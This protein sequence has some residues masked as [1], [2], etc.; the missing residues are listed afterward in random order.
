MKKQIE[1]NLLYNIPSKYIIP[2][3][4]AKKATPE[5][6]K[7]IPTQYNSIDT[8][9]KCIP[10]IDAITVGY[11]LLNHIDIVVTMAADGSIRLPFHNDEHKHVLE[12]F[13]PIETHASAQ[14]KNSPFESFTILKYMSPWYIKTP[15]DY[16]LLFVP[17]INRI[18]S[19]IIPLSGLVD[20]DSF[21]NVV[22]IP[23][24]HTAFEKPG[25]TIIIPAGTP[26]CQIVPIRR[27]DWSTKVTLLDAVTINEVISYREKIN[28][29]RKDWY[30]NNAHRKKSFN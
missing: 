9:K 23:F 2:P 30:K 13:P 18:E 7:N 22:N 27:D 5:W 4:P 15:K 12:A 25:D 19:S 11:I 8:V 24:I 28:K 21:K 14:A 3:I 26:I 6:L 29:D 20:T 17:L 1:F 10:F 16:S